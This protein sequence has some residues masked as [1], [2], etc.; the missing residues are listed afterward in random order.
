[1]ITFEARVSEALLH[2]SATS[3]A[4]RELI[5]AVGPCE[6]SPAWQRS[7]F[8]SLVRAVAHQQLQGKAAQ[9]ILG[10]FLALFAPSAFPM[11]ADILAVD[12]EVLRAVG[13]SRSK[14]LAIRDIAAKAAEGIV[15][16][17]EEA[18]ALSD[19]DLISRLVALRGVGQWTVEML[20]I[21]SL[22]RLDVF[23]LDDFGARKGLMI[24]FGLEA[25]PSK[26]E[27]LALTAC[28]RPYRSIGTWYLWRLV[29][30]QARLSKRAARAPR[31]ELSPD[32]D[33]GENRWEKPDEV[34][35]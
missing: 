14:I 10:R 21:F 32:G 3:P 35:P 34:L 27:M 18:E 33:N 30:N 7:P 11:P 29:A 2:L 25:M 31:A 13:F 24:A 22:G 17:R 20:L 5:S 16:T 26:R 9:A 6:L 4:M 15:P 1:M 12:E 23:P 28:W 8:E 19:D